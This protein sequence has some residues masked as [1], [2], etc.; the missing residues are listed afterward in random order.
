M[1]KTANQPNRERDTV[2]TEMHPLTLRTAS[3]LFLYTLR[4]NLFGQFSK[5]R[6]HMAQN[7]GGLSLGRRLDFIFEHGL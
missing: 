1:S 7:R 3:W 2:E 6:G 5:P 4:L